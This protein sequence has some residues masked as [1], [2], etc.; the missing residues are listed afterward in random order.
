MAL[1]GIFLHSAGILLQKMGSNG[2]DLKQLADLKH[3]RLTRGLI[4]W[5]SGLILAYWISIVPTAIASGPLSAEVV[6]AISG[7]GIVIIIV[8]SHIFLKEKLYHSDIMYSAVIVGCIFILGI[9]QKKDQI[10]AIDTAAL[11]IMSLSPL[12]LLIPVFSRKV[13]GRS[14]AV[15]LAAVSGLTGGVA[16]VMLNVAM[17]SGGSSFN[18]VFGS[19]Y[20]YEYSFIGFISGAFLQASYR[21]GDIIHIVPVQMSLTVVYPLV[22]SFFVFHRSLSIVQDVSI[23]TIAA[24]CWLILQKH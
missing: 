18:G 16:Y 4:V 10:A 14:K 22:C 20:I 21:F 7:L 2:L 8:L 3:F 23:I 6:S 1:L 5:I 13:P 17:K 15:L 19:P 11:Y 9:T 24:C 12:L